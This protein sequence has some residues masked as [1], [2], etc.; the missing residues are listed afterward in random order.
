MLAWP[1]K[2]QPSPT[3]F[4]AADTPHP[5]NPRQHTAVVLA[6]VPAPVLT[7]ILAPGLVRAGRSTL[8]AVQR[9]A[10][11]SHPARAATPR[12]S[13]H[14]VPTITTR[15]SD[16]H[17]RLTRP[18]LGCSK[19]RR[20]CWHRRC[21]MQPNR[22]PNRMVCSGTGNRTPICSGVCSG[23]RRRTDGDSVRSRCYPLSWGVRA[24]ARTWCAQEL[25]MMV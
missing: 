3:P 20:P 25:K 11:L 21:R 9:T 1:G 23:N 10:H 13:T 16:Q 24:C 5:R 8:S 17:T 19:C 12:P 6:P 18:P 2:S 7:P 14:A 22:T 4:K 15:V